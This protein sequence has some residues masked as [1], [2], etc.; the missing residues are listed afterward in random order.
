MGKEFKVILKRAQANDL[1][2]LLN[3]H[4]N[5]KEKVLK[6]IFNEFIK[7]FEYPYLYVVDKETIAKAILCGYEVEKTLQDE[8]LS[9][10]NRILEELEELENDD[11]HNAFGKLEGV[12]T[13]IQIM[14]NKGEWK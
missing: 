12:N 3:A 2:S 5:S 8:I 1:T 6:I 9:Y 13:I 7:D 11:Y 4:S 10:K 14:K